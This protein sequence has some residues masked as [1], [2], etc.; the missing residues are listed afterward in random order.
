MRELLFLIENLHNELDKTE[1]ST[2]I[3]FYKSTSCKLEFTKHINCDLH[4]VNINLRVSVNFQIFQYC[5][6]KRKT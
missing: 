2:K 4:I 3:P 5:T 1:N 6:L